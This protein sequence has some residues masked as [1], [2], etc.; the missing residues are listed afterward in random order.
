MNILVSAMGQRKLRRR[1]R[2]PPARAVAI[3]ILANEN[4]YLALC[5]ACAVVALDWKRQFSASR[6]HG[7]VRT[8]KAI[9]VVV[10]NEHITR[11]WV[12]KLELHWA[13]YRAPALLQGVETRQ[14]SAVGDARDVRGRRVAVCRAENTVYLPCSGLVGV[15]WT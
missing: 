13:T 6:A 14:A 2:G 12:M 11:T 9:L 1:D 10:T 4:N 3:E 15:T 5:K 7:A 8:G